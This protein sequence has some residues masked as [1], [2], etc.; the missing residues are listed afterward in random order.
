MDKYYTPNPIATLMV[1]SIKEESIGIIADFA[2]GDGFLLKKAS[3]K[4]PQATLYANDICPES[5]NLIKRNI[6]K[7]HFSCVDFLD[8]E[9]VSYNKILSKLHARCDLIL[10]NPPFSYRGRY[11]YYDSKLNTHIQCPKAIAFLITSLPFLSEEGKIVALIP[12]GALYGETSQEAWEYICSTSKINIISEFCHNAFS[13]CSART[14]LISIEKSNGG[15]SNIF[16][17]TKK[18]KFTITRGN[19]SMHTIHEDNSNGTPLVHSTSLTHSGLKLNGVC[20]THLSRTVS[21][22]VVLI[23]RV[24]NVCQHKVILYTRAEAVSLSDCI[25]AIEVASTNEGLAVVD[26]IKSNW[27]GFTEQ[28]KGTCAKHIT[29]SRLHNFLSIKFPY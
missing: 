12:E 22:P 2:A 16:S 28:Y 10:L 26:F 4:W 7:A 8:K 29:T 19:T 27:A 9:Q 21:G 5:R 20:G 3:Q 6:K 13:N 17:P 1:E 23:Q 14:I 24:G 25:F 15:T 18:S 11:R